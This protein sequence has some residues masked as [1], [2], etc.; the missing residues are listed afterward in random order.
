MSGDRVVHMALGVRPDG[1][2][3]EETT[4]F[5]RQDDI[6][7]P[8]GDHAPHPFVALSAGIDP[9]MFVVTA[10][11]DTGEPS[12]CLAAFVTQASIRPARLIVCLSD[13]NRTARVA[14]RVDHLA[15]HYLGRSNLDLAERFGG[16]TGD[17]VDK[18][19][20]CRW[21]RGPA[22][23]PLIDGTN[24]WV[25]L[26]ILD[27]IVAGDHIAHLGSVA[28]A[29]VENHE[30]QLGFAAVRHLSAGHAP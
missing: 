8:V 23:V 20:G 6:E 25:V 29:A 13:K 26:R 9:P 24:G 12:G 1:S 15:L 27:R 22:G 5:L 28:V 10:M 2:V 11:S 21:H 4:S 19:A 16:E 7:P 14:A 30:P 17:V 3:W 18:F